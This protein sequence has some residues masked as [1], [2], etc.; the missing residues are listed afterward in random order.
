MVCNS[1][2]P[3]PAEQ[4]AEMPGAQSPDDALHSRVRLPPA[5]PWW[6]VKIAFG[7]MVVL[8]LWS[9]VIAIS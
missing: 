6:V 9:Q 2:E 5:I 1:F 7:C 3:Q 8:G 4:T